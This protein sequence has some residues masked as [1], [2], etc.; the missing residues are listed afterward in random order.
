M[1]TS[2]TTHDL[3]RVV[4][5]S[6]IDNIGKGAAGQAVQNMNILLDLDETTGLKR[7]E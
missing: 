1:G 5:S 7:G 2:L 4:V 3:K 6:A